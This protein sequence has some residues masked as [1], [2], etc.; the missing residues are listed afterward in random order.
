MP[1]TS[2][3]QSQEEST[4]RMELGPDAFHE[5]DGLSIDCP[6]CGST[7]PLQFLITEGRCPNAL[8]PDEVEVETDVTSPQDVECSAKLDLELVW[9]A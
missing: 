6:Q 2:S 1:D 5:N 9:T 4:T 7:V 3:D 8:D